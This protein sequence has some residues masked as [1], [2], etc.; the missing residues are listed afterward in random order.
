MFFAAGC[1]KQPAKENKTVLPA[2]KVGIINMQQ[3]AQ[4]HPKY[5]QL[6]ALQ[7]QYAVMA[8]QLEAQRR[9]AA[10]AA[11]KAESGPLLPRED[12]EFAKSLEQERNERIAAKKQEEDA[13]LTAKEREVDRQLDQKM[14]AY[15][16]ELN[17]EY[18]PQLFNLQLKNEVLHPSGVAAQD[19]NAQTEKINKERQDKENAELQKLIAEK[20]QAMAPAVAAMHQ[21]MNTFIQ[22]LDAELNGKRAAQLEKEKAA[23]MQPL[24][25][26]TL[27]PAAAEEQQKLLEERRKIAD[28]QAEIINDIRDK[29]G[30]VANEKGLEAVL[31]NVVVNVNAQ[32]ITAEVIADYG[33]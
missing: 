1:G 5:K 28:L 2:E 24:P 9:A 21:R 11:G 22:A 23:A 31:T 15:N 17:K 14:A 20:E 27:P 25:A 12:A 19:I 33:K 32:D 8:A 26:E 29:A 10:L 4:A 7:Q 6:E 30:K 13:A 16:V 18:N 3:A